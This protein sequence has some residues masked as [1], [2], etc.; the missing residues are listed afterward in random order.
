[1]IGYLVFIISSFFFSI[2]EL[3]TNV[4]RYTAFKLIQKVYIFIL[5]ILF[6]FNRDNND[7]LNYV[8]IFNGEA[9]FSEKGY[10]FLIQLLKYLNGN[11]N[12]IILILGILL[13][14]VVFYLYNTNYPISLI[15]LYSIFCYVLDINQIRNLFCVLFVLI[16]ITFLQNKKK[17][18]Y[19]LFN[20]FGFLFHNIGYIY[21][22]FYFFQKLNIRKYK[23]VIFYLFI[24]SCLVLPFFKK[25][26]MELFPRQAPRY[27]FYKPNIGMIIYYFFAVTDI[28]ILSIGNKHKKLINEE[29]IYIKFILF[30]IIFLPSSYLTLEL[31]SRIYRNSFFIKWFYFFRY[32]KNKNRRIVILFLWVLLILQ[33][34]LF[35]GANLYNN[36]QKIINLLQQITNISFYF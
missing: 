13:L 29:K 9:S 33:Q 18:K 6:I 4:T 23:K 21:V 10:M 14:Y 22:L 34:F 7:Y 12:I 3:F 28:I 5:F 2:L 30:P 20:T 26:I 11:H 16:G 19:L 25:I 8:K 15:F 32:I 27:L 17:Y 31:I 35:L 24:C 1:M 36:P